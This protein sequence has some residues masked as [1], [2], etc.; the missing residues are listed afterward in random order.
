M[1]GRFSHSVHRKTLSA[2][3]HRVR[4]AVRGAARSAAFFPLTS[5]EIDEAI[6]W[7]MRDAPNDPAPYLLHHLRA[8]PERVNPVVVGAVYTPFLR[9]ALAAKAART[10]GRPF[11]P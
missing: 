9:V 11:T 1:K 5:T 2:G 10:D 6:A 8:A 7:G 4:S 3:I